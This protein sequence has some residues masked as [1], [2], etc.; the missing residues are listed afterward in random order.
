MV[1]G[2][3]GSLGSE[4]CSQ[5][6]DKGI[7]FIPITRSELDITININALEKFINNL[8]VNVIINCIAFLGI[9]N[10]KNNTELALE[11]NSFFPNKLF[12]ISKENNISF[13]QISTE[14]SFACDDIKIKNFE[15]DI[16]IPNTT[17]GLTKRLGECLKSENFYLVRL[18]LLFG[19][20]HKN[21]II[22]K[23]T[24]T[25]FN[26]D[27]IKVSND[28]YTTPIY[29]PFVANW[30]IENV[31]DN[32]KS[33]PNIIHLNSSKR[34]SMYDFMVKILTPFNKDS[35][36][37]PVSSDLFP[38]SEP[39]PK[40]GGLSSQHHKGFDLDTMINSY[41]KIISGLN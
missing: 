11:I 5:L 7:E 19:S 34:I 20:T 23:L 9:E 1:L 41:I 39:K 17:Y 22:S 26:D 33:F 28:I 35:M 8:K 24:S 29:T 27:N 31:I 6:S 30:I 36:V 37:L 10:C 16:A 13:I 38:S 21:Q 4:I 3:N 14:C 12:T 18:P 15:N 2:A 25:A 40:F 32:F